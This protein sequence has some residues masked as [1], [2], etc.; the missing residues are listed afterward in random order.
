MTIY[1]TFVLLYGKNINGHNKISEGV[2]P[3]FAMPYKDW[4]FVLQNYIK[5]RVCEPLSYTVFARLITRKRLLYVLRSYI[6][7][8]KIIAILRAYS[9]LIQLLQI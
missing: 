7:I 4:S 5:K 3:P 2:T 9:V 8:F 6:L 1:F